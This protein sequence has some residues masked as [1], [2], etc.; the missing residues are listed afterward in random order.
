MTLPP[1]LSI[2]NLVKLFPAGRSGIFSKQDRFVHALDGVSFDLERGGVLALAGESG[3]GKS[4]LALTLMAWNAPPPAR[5][6]STAR[7]SPICKAP[8]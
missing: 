7:R 5:S 8:G 2:R 3:C 1:I 4:T 6:S